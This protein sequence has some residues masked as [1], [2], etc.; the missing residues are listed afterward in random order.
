[1]K[2]TA[3]V[4]GATGL[5]GSNVVN[6]LVTAPHIKFIITLT[7]RPAPH[8]SSKVSNTVVNFDALASHAAYFNADMLFLCLGTTRSQAGSIA[9]QR[10]VDV[11]YQL[12]A[13]TVAVKQGVGHLLLVSSSGA[14]TQSNSPYLKMKGELEQQVK[15]LSF[16]H[17]SIVQPSLLIGQRDHFRL[18]ETL[19]SW[20]MPLLCSLPVLRRYRPIR[21]EQVAQ[22]LMEL[23]KQPSAPLETRRLD[24]VFPVP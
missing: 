3:V 19:A 1:M 11:D 22:R 23:S 17:I 24:E 7:R 9:A 13:A 21:G 5:V 20:I 10:V 4:V 2:K 8:P 16:K 15:M 14:N 6:Q 18:G 12:S